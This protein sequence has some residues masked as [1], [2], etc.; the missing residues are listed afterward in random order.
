ML[1]L[2]LVP[3]SGNLANI[4]GVNIACI[5]TFLI[6]LRYHLIVHRVYRDVNGT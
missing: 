2:F 1:I 5:F 3:H 4:L 6:P